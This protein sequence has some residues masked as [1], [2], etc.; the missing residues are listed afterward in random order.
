MVWRRLFWILP[1]GIYGNLEVPERAAPGFHS[2]RRHPCV[3]VQFVNGEVAMFDRRQDPRQPHVLHMGDCSELRPVETHCYSPGYFP[4]G[5]P[6]IKIR[7][8]KAAV[9]DLVASGAGESGRMK[10]IVRKRDILPGIA[11]ASLKL[12]HGEPAFSS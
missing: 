10:N 1:N 4:A 9:V 6:G 3:P 7:D 2:V 8:L 12:I 5:N 11:S